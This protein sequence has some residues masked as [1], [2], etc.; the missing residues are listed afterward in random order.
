MALI[1]N[2]S[3]I[4]NNGSMASGFGGSMTFIKKLTASASA[5]LSFVDGTDGVVLDG[6]YKEYVFTFNNLHAQTHEVWLQFQ[7]STNGGSNYNTSCTSTNF[8]AHH[9]EGDG[10]TGINYYDEKDHANDTGY[11]YLAAW[12]QGNDDDQSTSGTL[13]LYNPSDTTFVKHWLCTLNISHPADFTA[14]GYSA[15]YFNTTSAINA[16]SFKFTSGN[17]DAGDICLYG[18]A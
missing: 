16:I 14:N 3:T 11:I 9:N 13:N 5:T 15:G 2:G 6:T 17:I 1:S 12:E 8:L 18:I 10:N 7:T 4:F